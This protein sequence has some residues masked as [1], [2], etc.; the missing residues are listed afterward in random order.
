MKIFALIIILTL[1][2]HI[3]SL[4][5]DYFCTKLN[6]NNC[7]NYDCGTKLC[8]ID[9]KSCSNFIKWENL[10]KKYVKKDIERI[11]YNKFMKSV[12]RCNKKQIDGFMLPDNY[13]KKHDLNVKCEIYSCGNKY[14]SINKQS[15]DFLLSFEN[16]MSGYIRQD[17][18]R[19][20]FETFLSNIKICKSNGQI[21]FKNQWTHR[22]NFG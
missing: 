19:K 6:N 11:K 5:P 1:V 10:M 2:F 18:K 8:S 22:L 13:C 4:K 9:E 17:V 15:C 3:K 16:L 7:F 12:K 14:C 21:G 20:K